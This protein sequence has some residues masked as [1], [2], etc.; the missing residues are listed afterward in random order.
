MDGSFPHISRTPLCQCTQPRRSSHAVGHAVGG[1][2][3]LSSGV[4][5]ARGEAGHA[6]RNGLFSSLIPAVLTV[7]VGPHRVLPFVNGFATSRTLS[8]K[9]RAVEP[10]VR[11]FKVTIPTGAN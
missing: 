1:W 5:Q 10:R 4:D 8:M 7:E 3:K 11:F 2:S 9:R 6:R